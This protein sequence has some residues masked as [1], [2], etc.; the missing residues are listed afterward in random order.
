MKTIRISV[1]AI[2]TLIALTALLP[3][4]GNDEE[5]DE[6]E[7]EVTIEKLT[8]VKDTGKDF[9]P[10][11]KFKPTD[12]FGVLVQ[13]SE[14]LEGTVV[15]GVWTAVDAGELQDQQISE[16]KVEFTPETIKTAKNPSRVDFTLAHENP[17]PA[18]DYKFEVYLDGKLADSVEFKVEE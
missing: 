11:K 13:L 1:F 2:S 7:N 5:D 10:V 12:T 15:E 14:A 8:L 17:Y 9:Q 4:A 16:K 18:G 3:A 6:S